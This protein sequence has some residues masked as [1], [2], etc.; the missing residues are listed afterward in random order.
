MP[1]PIGKSAVATGKSAVASD[2]PQKRMTLELRASFLEVL[3][4][5]GVV[6]KAAGAIGRSTACCYNLR[7]RDAGFAAQWQ[8]A[9]DQ[10]SDTLRAIAI[11][12]AVKGVTKTIYHLGKAVG[13]QREYSDRLLMFL[14]ERHP[15]TAA[16]AERAAASEK[17]AEAEAD[18]AALT[19]KID[20]ALAGRAAL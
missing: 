7:Q 4:T 15:A 14:L 13:R 20:A 2:G 6:V 9:L 1:K 10:Y 3:A 12:R 5:T 16:P 17:A 8:Q 11:E 19:A 18:A